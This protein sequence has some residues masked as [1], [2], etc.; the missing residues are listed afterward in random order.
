MSMVK[1]ATRLKNDP[2]HRRKLLEKLEDVAET[3]GIV[4]LKV[5]NS[6]IPLYGFRLNSNI[7]SP[8]HVRM[9]YFDTT[10][11]SVGEMSGYSAG[12]GAITANIPPGGQMLIG[13]GADGGAP[14]RFSLSST[15]PKELGYMKVY[16]ST[17]ELELNHIEQ[18]SSFELRPGD[19]R[20]ADQ[21][22]IAFNSQWGTACLK[23]ILRK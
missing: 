6:P 18:K 1:V 12:S 11:F 20:G 22:R 4:E 14:I 8:L 9:F 13:D 10:D 17:D 15:K 16:W 2:L 5:E 3:D 23:L 21:E 7:K 19:L